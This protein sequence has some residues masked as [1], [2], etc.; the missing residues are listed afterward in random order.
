MGVLAFAC[1]NESD[2]DEEK[3]EGEVELHS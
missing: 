3:A 1:C 2:E